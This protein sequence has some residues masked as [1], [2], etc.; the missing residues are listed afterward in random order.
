[1][2]CANW[3]RQL[4]GLAI[5]AGLTGVLVTALAQTVRADDEGENPEIVGAWAVAVTLRDCATAA[6]MESFL[7]LVTFQSGGTLS[8]SSGGLAFLPEQRSEGHGAWKQLRRRTF[9]QHVIALLRF[10]SPANLPGTPGFDPTKPISPGFSAGWQTISHTVRMTG[11][12]SFES[13]GGTEFF[14]SSGQS[15]RTGC[16]TAV[17]QRFE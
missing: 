11:S 4:Y 1:M 12:D 3:K 5:S 8:E 14:N 6:P 9:S 15:Y 16:S 2:T 13:S 10:A 17:G 7:S